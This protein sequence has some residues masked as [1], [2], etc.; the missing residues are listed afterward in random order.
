M[1]FMKAEGHFLVNF[2]P[3]LKY[4]LIRMKLRSFLGQ[5]ATASP[6]SKHF[7]L[8]FLAKQNF[9]HVYCLYFLILIYATPP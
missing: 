6:Y 4:L 5:I 1:S 2:Q 7:L 8:F 3:F 9:V